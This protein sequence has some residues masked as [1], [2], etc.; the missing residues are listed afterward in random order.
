MKSLSRVQIFMTPWTATY[1]APLSMG[2]SRQEY[3]SGVPLPSPPFTSG[4]HL[5]QCLVCDPD[6]LYEGK[7]FKLVALIL[8]MNILNTKPSIKIFSG[9][10]QALALPSLPSF[11]Q[12]TQQLKQKSRLPWIVQASFKVHRRSPFRLEKYFFCS[13]TDTDTGFL[14]LPIF[15]LLYQACSS[16]QAFPHLL[17]FL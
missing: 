17:R 5:K 6:P 2:F 8:Q 14:S 12:G 9:G 13:H 4:I 3:W 1:Q 7:S 15:W 11:R 10:E 16:R